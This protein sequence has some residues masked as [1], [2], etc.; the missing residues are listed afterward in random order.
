MYLGI[1]GLLEGVGVVMWPI[2]TYHY[3]M[4][5]VPASAEE[6]HARLL[7]SVMGALPSFFCG[8]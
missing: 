6:L 5:V 2:A 7:K 4:S 3:F 8:N 1:Y